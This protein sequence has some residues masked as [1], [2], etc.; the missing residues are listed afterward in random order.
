MPDAAIGES[1]QRLIIRKL[2]GA[3]AEQF[4][5]GVLV[6]KLASLALAASRDRQGVV[7]ALESPSRAMRVVLGY[8]AFTRRGAAGDEYARIA[9]SSLETMAADDEGFERLLSTPDPPSLWPSFLEE[10]ERRNRKANEQLNRWLI[11]G[12][13][14]MAHRTRQ[15]DGEGNIFHGIRDGVIRSGHVHPHFDRLTSIRGVGPKIASLLLRDVCWLYNLEHLVAPGDRLLL[16]PVD[17]WLRR[18]ADRL[19]EEVSGEQTPDWVIAGKVAKLTR[20]AGVSGIAFNMGVQYFGLREARH[21]GG[22]ARAFRSLT[23]P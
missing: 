23:D 1:C 20:R 19:T 22:F 18:V 15:E 12:F 16:Q 14:G 2:A 13:L 10:C 4:Q 3:K 7:E 5:N 17:A 8:Y 6:P 21:A 11:D 9:L